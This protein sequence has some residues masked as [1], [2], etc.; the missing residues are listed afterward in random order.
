[1]VDLSD[2]DR[3]ADQRNPPCPRLKLAGHARGG[4]PVPVVGTMPPVVMRAGKRRRSFNG[5]L[6]GSVTVELV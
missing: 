6:T 3:S 5:C 4:V 2:F 1:M